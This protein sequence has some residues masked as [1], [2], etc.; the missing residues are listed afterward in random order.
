M[1]NETNIVLASA[2]AG[3]L[4]CACGAPSS[5]VDA[6][7]EAETGSSG[8][9]DPGIA[10][11]LVIPAP[12]GPCPELGDG[13]VMFCP[14]SLSVCRRAHVINAEEA[15]GSGPLNVYWHGTFESPEGILADDSAVEQL[16][17]M[18]VAEGGLMVVPYADPEAL[19]RPDT[20]FPW[21][22]VVGDGDREAL[23]GDREDDFVLLDQ[24]VAC[25]V[26]AGLADPHRINISGMS[27]G[28]IMTSHV[29]D[30]RSYVAAAVPWSGG[31]PSDLQPSAPQG[32]VAVMVLHGG[33][34]DTYCGEGVDSCY[35][36]R[37]PSEAFALDVV[38]GG[39]WA[40]LCDHQAGHATAMGAEAAVFLAMSRWGA[41]P[42]TG[43]D[44]ASSTRLDGASSGTHWVVNNYCYDPGE[45]GPWD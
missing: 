2:V 41:H 5:A 21:W 10:Q 14:A 40:F 17:T 22:V 1:S 16:R 38:E 9:G 29:V 32:P 8:I 24:I 20:P 7:T 19:R 43:Y 31:I 36:F 34:D 33:D 15:D 27:A 42:W 23:G 44:V 30:R 6:D 4:C 26:Q 18:S 13:S 39:A 3:A 11:E 37:P 12:D 28:G 25:V 35:S 45:P